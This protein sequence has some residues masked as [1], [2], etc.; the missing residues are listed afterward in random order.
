[1][2]IQKDN[3]KKR[4]S[5]LEEHEPREGNRLSYKLFQC[6]GSRKSSRGSLGDTEQWEGGTRVSKKR[7]VAYRESE[8][9]KR[10]VPNHLLTGN[11][12]EPVQGNA[13]NLNWILAKGRVKQKTTGTFYLSKQGEVLRGGGGKTGISFSLFNSGVGGRFFY[14]KV[15]SWEMLSKS[16]LV[17]LK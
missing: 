5:K 16:R 14:G 13:R 2:V 15:E 11:T 9:L 1:V 4:P 12:R 8:L 7:L 6:R 3:R 17:G 10:N